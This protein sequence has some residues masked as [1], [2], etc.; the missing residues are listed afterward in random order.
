[1]KYLQMFNE[2]TNYI[3]E[4]YSFKMTRDEAKNRVLKNEDIYKN[5]EFQQKFECFIKAWDKIKKNA[6]KYKC[7]PEMPI[8]DLD[9]N[10]KLTYFLNDDKEIYNGMYIA[11][12]YQNFIDWQNT[13][14]QPIIDSNNSDGIL[15]QYVCNMK[16]KILIQ[17][18]KNEQI[19]LIEERYKK[20]SLKNFNN[21]INIFSERN[22]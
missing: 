18:S 3:I 5:E 19:L 15:Y 2:F 20:S 14:L 17:Y 11:S 22:I 13:F 10:D 8:K 4:N 21:I 16:K 9:S 1:M 12:A 6:I 7:N